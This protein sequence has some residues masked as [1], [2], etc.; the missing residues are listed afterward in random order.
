[1]VAVEMDC[2]WMAGVFARKVPQASTA[3][4]SYARWEPRVLRVSIGH[5]HGTVLDMEFASMENV[6]V[7]II[8]LRPIAQYQRNAMELATKFAWLILLGPL[9]SSAKDSVSHLPPTLLSGTTTLCW[10]AL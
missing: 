10:L 9:A 1:M 2:A 8:T 4:E 5:A 7:T 6:L 3:A